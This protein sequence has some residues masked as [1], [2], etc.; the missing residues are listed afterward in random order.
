MSMFNPC[1]ICGADDW[2]FIYEGPIRNGAF[3]TQAEGGKVALC[4]GCG[5]ARLD[6]KMSIPISAYESDK[7]RSILEQGLEVKAFFSQH[8]WIQIQNLLAFWPLCLRDQI[9]AEIGCGAGSFLDHITGMAKRIIAVEPTELY[10]NS[11]RQRGYEVY[12]YAADAV[13]YHPEGID[14]VVTFQVIEHVLNPRIFLTEIAALLKPGGTLIVATPNRED[15]LM[16]LLPEEF[17]SFFYRTVHRWYFDRLSLRHCVELAGGLKVESERYLHT[18]GMSNALA[19]LK[20]RRPTG[21]K[22][23]PGINNVADQLWNS[24]LETSEQADTLFI[25]ARKAKVD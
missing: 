15:V 4:G 16:K 2:S 13:K 1:E 3:G 19:W 25:L 23:L 18:Y 11:L 21:N 7:Y 12:S 5:I 6:E 20:E 17:P 24:Y 9:I 8:D 14:V 10:H 22:R